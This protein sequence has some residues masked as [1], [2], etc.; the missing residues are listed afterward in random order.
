MM[1]SQLPPVGAM[2]TP[3]TGPESP[4]AVPELAPTGLKN[5]ATDSTPALKF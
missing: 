1:K 4:L 5:G 2:R 3:V